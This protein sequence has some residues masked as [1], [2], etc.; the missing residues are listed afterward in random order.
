RTE[1]EA[2]A[3]IAVRGLVKRYGDRTVIDGLDLTIAR[4][5]TYALLGPNG[6]GKSTTIEI[7][8]GYRKATSGEVLVLGQDPARAPRSWR[9]RIGIVSQQTG[10]MGPF[11]P[12]E[13]IAH[14]RASYPNP[15]EV[16]EVL[17]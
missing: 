16:D 5:E 13:L 17:E 8:E 11:T 9:A 2:N 6:A 12:R 10:D 1:L 3:A 14:F 4:G 15:R 7:L